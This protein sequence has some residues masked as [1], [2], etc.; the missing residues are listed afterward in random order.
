MPHRAASLFGTLLATTA[1]AAPALAQTSGDTALEEVVVT[2]QRRAERLQDV[3]FSISAIAGEDLKK[4][5]IT[6]TRD[7]TLVTPGLLFSQSAS[8]PQP[9]IRGVGSRATQSGDESVVPIYIDGVYQPWS[10][11][12]ITDLVDVERVEILRG[13]QSALYGRNSTGGAINIVTRTPRADDP[14]AELR[15]SYGSFDDRQVDAY[16]SGG[17]GMFAGSLAVHTRKDDGY[18]KDV[19]LQKKAAISDFTTIRAKLVFKP[20]DRF[21]STLSLGYV[22]QL[23]GTPTAIGPLNRNAAVRRL[24]PNVF[25]P[26]DF[27]TIALSHNRP[28]KILQNSAS[29]TSVYHADAFD[30]TSITGYSWGKNKGANDT[31]S[32][33]LNILDPAFVFMD[34]G[35]IQEVYAT[36]RGDG[37]LQWI[38]GGVFFHDIAKSAPISSQS[39]SVAGATRGQVTNT[40][41]NSKNKTDSYA[42]YAQVDYAVTDRLKAIISGRITRE[43]KVFRTHVVSTNLTTGA[44]TITTPPVASKT[45]SQF[46]PT[47]TLQYEVNDDMQVYVRVGNGF[48]SGIFNTA[49]ANTTPVDPEKVLQYEAG[50]KGNLGDRVSYSLAAFY[51]TQKDMQIS[52]RNPITQATSTQNAASA[53]SKGFEAEVFMRPTSNLDLSLGVS[54]LD[55]YFDDFPNAV[56]TIPATEVDPPAATPCQVGTGAFIGGNRSVICDVTDKKLP[57]APNFMAFIGGSYT[58]P[59]NVG[60][61]VISANYNWTSKYYWE[62]YNRLT[63][64]AHETVSGQI[65]WSMNDHYEIAVFGQ[66]L[67]QNHAYLAIS[68]SGTSDNRSWARPR[69]YGVRISAKY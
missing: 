27:L 59:L 35:I 10:Y 61:V 29:L 13:P 62:T 53:V 54:V 50:A 63:Q 46:T 30:L 20:S 49:S 42:A 16:V 1:L 32:T 58:I 43:R 4:S 23:D 65:A 3:P 44:R 24:F 26:T 52:A 64:P 5:G 19:F 34:E 25:I 66:N 6:S 8:A 51:V 39:V 68:P 22:N 55:A 15:A 48:K 7:L 28:V 11:G 36:S 18:V 9:S 37:R 12:G 40:F 41:V 56:V 47:G 2:A 21:D 67:T 14:R 17:S 38:V 57:R 33:S 31:D 69:S 45:W 60:K